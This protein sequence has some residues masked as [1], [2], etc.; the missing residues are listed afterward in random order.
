MANVLFLR[1]DSA[2]W[3]RQ[4]AS[5]LK[6]VIEG[7]ISHAINISNAACDLALRSSRRPHRINNLERLKCYEATAKIFRKRENG[8]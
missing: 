1:N 5:A 7:D 2:F 4:T 8:A 3:R 6:L